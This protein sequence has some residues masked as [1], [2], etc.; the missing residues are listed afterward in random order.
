ME[1]A[2]RGNSTT[3]R[4]KNDQR[5]DEEWS[6]ERRAA[7]DDDR[8]DGI[9]QRVHSIQ[10]DFPFVCQVDV[11]WLRLSLV[12][13]IPCVKILFVAFTATVFLYYYNSV[14][15]NQMIVYTIQI[16]ACVHHSIT[17]C[18]TGGI[19]AQR[20]LDMVMVAAERLN[21]MLLD[22]RQICQ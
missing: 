6:T 5:H 12:L 14:K 21:C 2:C 7:V 22:Y 3:R 4:G 15:M 1:S 18:A 8:C 17:H 9:A 13:S 16:T 20:E 19:G 10:C 11:A